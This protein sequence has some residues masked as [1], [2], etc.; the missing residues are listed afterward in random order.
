[1]VTTASPLRTVERILL[2]AV[3]SRSSI[4]L[5]NSADFFSSSFSSF[6]VSSMMALSSSCL[7]FRWVSFSAIF[8]FAASMI[9]FFCAILASYSRMCFSA[10]WISRSW[11]SISLEMESNS[12]LFLTFFCCSWYF[13]ERALASSMLFLLFAM[14]VSRF[15]MSVLKLLKRVCRPA[16]SSSRSLTSRGSSP[17]MFLISSILESMSCKS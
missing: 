17:L 5:L 6:S 1:M 10:S 4:C 12:L 15:S 14:A 8:S 3:S 11:Y 2:Y 9:S 13:L 16:I 7:C